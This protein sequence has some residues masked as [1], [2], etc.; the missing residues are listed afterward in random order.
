MPKDDKNLKEAIASAKYIYEKL[1][2]G[3]STDKKTVSFL[4]AETFFLLSVVHKWG[5]DN[6]ATGEDRVD[7]LQGYEGYNLAGKTVV[8][9]NAVRIERQI[10]FQQWLDRLPSVFPRCTI[11]EF[12]LDEQLDSQGNRTGIYSPRAYLSPSAQIITGQ[13]GGP[14]S[15]VNPPPPPK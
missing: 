7:W 1:V 2:A 5:E 13:G 3:V 4:K 15:T 12:Y 11:I 6:S 10:F 8:E 9:I 14:N